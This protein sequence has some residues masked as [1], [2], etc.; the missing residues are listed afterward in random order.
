M[1]LKDYFSYY[2]KAELEGEAIYSLLNETSILEAENIL[3]EEGFD[4]MNIYFKLLANILYLEKDSNKH[5]E[6]IAYLYYLIAY[7][8]GLFAHPNNGDEI[9]LHYLKKA[10]QKTK[11][12][13]LKNDC[14]I[15]R[16]M[17]LEENIDTLKED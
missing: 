2:A 13:S 17:I 6:E 11:R 14:R 12:E 1:T 16:Q 8:L 15:T 3:R 5:G 10:E 7:Y 9:A 4:P